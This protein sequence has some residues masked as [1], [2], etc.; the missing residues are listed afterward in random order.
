[1]RVSV[2]VA[3]EVDVARRP[4]TPKRRHAKTPA[5]VHGT[6]LRDDVQ[7]DGAGAAPPDATEGLRVIKRYGNRRLYDARLSRC[8]TVAEIAGFIRDGDDVRVVEGEGGVDLTRKILVQI[9]VDEEPLLQA[10]PVELLHQLIAARE[11][12]LRQWI[13]LFLGV[14]AKWLAQRDPRPHDSGYEEEDLRLEVEELRQRLSELHARG[15]RR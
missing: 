5:P 4:A 8:V 7:V 12:P 6:H 13:G 10:L 11:A 15:R 14:G 2:R 9:L 1:M 3:E